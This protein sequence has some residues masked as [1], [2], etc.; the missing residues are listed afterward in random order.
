MRR[1]ENTERD[2][3]VV[4][5]VSGGGTYT[6]V[7]VLAGI[8]RNAVSGIMFRHNNPGLYKPKPK[9]LKFAGAEAAPL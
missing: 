1:R 2:Q 9:L 8:T 4:D 5:L 7:A 6:T 3:R